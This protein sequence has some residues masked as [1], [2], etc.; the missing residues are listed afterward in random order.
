MRD[1]TRY[2]VMRVTY[3]DSQPVPMPAELHDSIASAIGRGLL[4]PAGVELVDEYDVQV[5]KRRIDTI[6]Y[7]D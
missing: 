7:K 6:T 4:T 5:T 3:D 1:N 2:V